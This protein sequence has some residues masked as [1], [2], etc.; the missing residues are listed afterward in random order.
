MTAM[1]K[2]T[3]PDV[4]ALLLGS[5]REKP[6]ATAVVVGESALT[7]REFEAAS[8]ALAAR[9]RTA[10]VRRGQ[11]VLLYLR[12]SVHTV[13]GMAAA[14]R[15][16]AAWCVVEPGHP[17]KRVETLLHDVD[18]AALVLDRADS[19]DTV[20]VRDVVSALV[21]AAPRPLAVLETGDAQH[22]YGPAPGAEPAPDV[23]VPGAL[24][25]YVITTSGS[26][27][28]PK[29]IVVSR[30]NLAHMVAARRDEPGRPTF[31]TCRLTWDGSLLLLF[32]ALCTG[33][34]A[35]LADHRALP[36]ASACAELVL[37]R[38]VTQLVSPP[39][40]YRLMLPHLA[41]ADAHLRE[42]LVAGETFPEALIAQHRAVLPGTRLRNEYGPTEVTITVLAHPV[43]GPYGGNVPLGTPL[44]T[45]TAHVLDE[46][47]RPAP[48]GQLGELYLGGAQVTQGYAA[49][50]G[51]TAQRFVADPFSAGPGARMYRTGD[52]V[53]VNEA[54]EIE[55]HGRADGQLKVRGVR[56]ERHAVEATLESHPAVRQAVVL[57]APDEYGDTRLVA[58]WAPAA[59]A[60]AL[61]DTRELIELCAA[62][63]H[64]QAVPE[65]FVTVG[66]MPLAA[67][68]KTD[69]AALLALLPDAPGPPADG[70]GSGWTPLQSAVARLWARVLK[71]DRFG[72]RDSFFSVGGNSHRVV[73][74]HLGL[75]REWPGAVRVGQ[76]FD[77]DTVEAQAAALAGAQSRERTDRNDGRPGERQ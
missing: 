44:G 65:T 30:D 7:Y 74:V 60:V 29:A 55:F 14:L 75:Q 10:G 77:L 24:P 72:L 43:N 22:P 26:T 31:S 41:G 15:L 59:T 35:V 25:A 56:V 73:E 67:T 23:D 20:R 12:Q 1:V 42:V 71:H 46:R 16:G 76:L 21:D 61:P 11:T 49:R 19:P 51:G 66:A 50:P 32:Q 17:M 4:L 8:A 58:F 54:G 52:L 27:G 2:P 9:L 34:T 18:C 48:A 69:E 45:T 3:V 39:S 62:H 47:L 40:F 64:D 6:E 57:G 37:R 63:H 70:A 13:V 38:R 36:D 33:G 68:G 53:H 5:T 28:E